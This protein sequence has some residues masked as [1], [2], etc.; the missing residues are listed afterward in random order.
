MRR[1]LIAAAVLAAALALSACGSDEAAGPSTSSSSSN[2]PTKTQTIETR[3]AEPKT[4]T[5]IG[6]AIKAKIPQ[7]SKVVT[8][9]EDNDPNDKI[10]RPGGYV[11]GAVL[12]DSRAEPTGKE[13]GVDQ[14][15]F[16]EVWPD[17][18]AATDRSKFIQNALKTADGVLGNE[19]HYQHKGFL[20]RVT[21][22]VKPSQAKAYESAFNAQFQGS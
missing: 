16:L 15:A 21:G 5:E 19:Y 6:D 13:P 8:I 9:T 2:E 20:L 3:A 22:E 12:F 4:A 11:D 18:A 14:G 7:I 1:P 10:G 17:E